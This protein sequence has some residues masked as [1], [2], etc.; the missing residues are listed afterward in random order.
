[1]KRLRSTKVCDWLSKNLDE[2]V[3][4]RRR[5]SLSCVLVSAKYGWS[6]NTEKYAEDGRVIYTFNTVYSW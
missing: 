4:C 1:M 2:K 3:P 5:I 6:V